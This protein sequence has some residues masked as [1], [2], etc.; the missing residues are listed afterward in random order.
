MSTPLLERP[1]VVDND[2]VEQIETSDDPGQSTHI[3]LIPR[4]RKGTTIPQ[5]CF[6]EAIFNGTAIE[7]LCGHKWVPSKD[8]RR[9]PICTRCKAIFEY[10]P[11]GHNDRDQLPED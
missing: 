10:D 7:A 9:L 11:H 1:P 5:A 6:T 8:P 4:D 3:I 2:V